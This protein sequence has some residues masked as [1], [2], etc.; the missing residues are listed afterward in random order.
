MKP[1]TIIFVF[2]ISIILHSCAAEDPLPTSGE[3]SFITQLNGKRYVAEDIHVFPSGTKY[4]LSVY[5]NEKIWLL[6][7]NNSSA[8]TLYFYLYE[9]TGSGDYMIGEADENLSFFDNED[10]QTSVLIGD[11]SLDVLFL[12][13]AIDATE[14]IKITEVQGDSIIIGEF[15]KI[16]LTDPENPNNTAI[17][18]D[19]KFNINL[20]TLNQ[21][22]L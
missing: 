13:K 12:T 4:G 20:N 1:L 3:N 11:G 6:T 18:T 8:L 2:L 19:G 14:Y 16:T 7:V 15:E 5:K 17:L 10:N 9:I 21:P 22:E